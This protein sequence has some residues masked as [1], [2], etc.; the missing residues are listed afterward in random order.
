MIAT[1]LLSFG[2]LFLAE[3]GDKSQVMTLTFALRYRWPAVLAG[4]TVATLLVD[5]I[6]VG[7]GHSLGISVPTRAIALAM[8]VV[9]V[10]VAAWTLRDAAVR[11]PPAPPPPPAAHEQPARAFLVVLSSFLLAELGDRTMFATFALASN[12][13][14]VAVWIGSVTGMV[15]A[16]A[17]A[18]VVGTT[19]G[20]RLPRRSIEIASG[21]LFVFLGTLSLLSAAMPRW[22]RVAELLLAA[23]VTLAVAGVLWLLRWRWP[24]GR[25]QGALASR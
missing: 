19:V 14:A 7:I 13:N 12:H 11:R 17:L 9:L 23:A 16:G 4:I 2:A 3:L 22:D 25:D 10:V 15:A 1:I 6:A 21:L 20:T 5:L 8:G 24:P 18:I